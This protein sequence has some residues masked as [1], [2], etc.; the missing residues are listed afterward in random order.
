LSD[1]EW[2]A[3]NSLKQLATAQADFR[4]ADRDNNG[5]RDF[6]TADV[7]GL[8]AIDNTSTDA[9]VPTAI[10]LIEL[11][12][13][14]ADLSATSGTLSNG[15][16]SNPISNFGVS[17]AKAGYWFMALKEDKQVTADGG[18]GVYRQDTDE[19]GKLVHN[20][21]RFGF[22]AIPEE[23]GISG[24]RVLILNENNVVMWRDF[25]EELLA[26]GSTPPVLTGVF[27]GNW[28]TNEELEKHWHTEDLASPK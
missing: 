7:A 9:P 23:Y 2:A 16:Y 19:S 6:W 18:S 26:A 5:S 3:A 20:T 12:V 24:T 17:A 25:G 28:P 27:D 11:S 21:S 4:S 14:L 15:N 1:D 10:R 22:A 8:Y 13:A